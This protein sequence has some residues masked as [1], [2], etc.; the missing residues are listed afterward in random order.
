M[1]NGVILTG[2]EEGRLAAW[3]PTSSSCTDGDGDVE[4][5]D[6]SA[7]IGSKRSRNDR[8]PEVCI[9]LLFFSELIVLIEQGAKR[10]RYGGE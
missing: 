4:M 7:D 10:R 1:Q 2:D 8:Q 3:R 9:K 6:E 5:E